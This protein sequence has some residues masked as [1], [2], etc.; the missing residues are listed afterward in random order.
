MYTVYRP[1]PLSSRRK[2]KVKK[3]EHGERREDEEGEWRRKEKG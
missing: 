3:E 1:K 2:L